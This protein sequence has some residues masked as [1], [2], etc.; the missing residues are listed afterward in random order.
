MLSYGLEALFILDTSLV[1]L[2]PMVR[3]ADS[4]LT[5]KFLTFA[6]IFFAFV[7]QCSMPSHHNSI[8]APVA[9][10]YCNYFFAWSPNSEENKW[11]QSFH[12][13]LPLYAFLLSKFV[14]IRCMME[15]CRGDGRLS[16]DIPMYV[17]AVLYCSSGPS[18]SEVLWYPRT[19]LWTFGKHLEASLMTL[20]QCYSA[21]HKRF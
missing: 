3:H 17:C 19:G 21:W 15:L 11:S 9:S 5:M 7:E 14:Y 13:V 18:S 4:T 12:T 8:P 20:L 16:G 2:L 10:N 1:W 6:D